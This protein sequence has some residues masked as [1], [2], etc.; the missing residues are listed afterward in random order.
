MTDTTRFTTVA[1]V[2]AAIATG[3]TDF[4]H[5]TFSCEF[6]G[7]PAVNFSG[8]N[9]SDALFEQPVSHSRFNGAN[10]SGTVFAQA[11]D[12]CDFQSTA[13]SDTRFRGTLDNSN[14]R[15][16]TLERV[17]IDGAFGHNDL[18]GA[19]LTDVTFSGGVDTNDFGGSKLYHVQFFGPVTGNNFAVTV[20][21]S[22]AF[23]N[24]VISN[25][26]FGPAFRA[27]N[28][29]TSNS[30]MADN[31]Y[32]LPNL[33]RDAAALTTITAPFSV[34]KDFVAGDLPTSGLLSAVSAL[35]QTPQGERYL[36]EHTV[37][38]D[39]ATQQFAVYFDGIH[40]PEGVV[41]HLS[42]DEAL[43]YNGAR[44]SIGA[45]VLEAAWAKLVTDPQY[46]GDLA[47][48]TPWLLEKA[49]LMI[50]PDKAAP[51]IDPFYALT[52]HHADAISMES[53]RDY[54]AQPGHENSV[55]TASR[56]VFLGQEGISL[57][58]SQVN[59]ASI[60]G[61]GEFPNFQAMN[62]ALN[63][64]GITATAPYQTSQPM[65]LTDAQAANVFDNGPINREVYAFD[66]DWIADKLA[67]SGMS[68][69]VDADGTQAA[70]DAT[71]M[72]SR[73]GVL[74]L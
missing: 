32:A 24:S 26:E 74:A 6:N 39:P 51:L 71:A 49:G 54:A 41:I 28:T 69:V 58:N 46:K 7:S 15:L 12:D 65:E 33:E 68:S 22:V 10:L 38:Y 21:D 56:G 42:Y 17:A 3:R 63:E 37:Q 45:T 18:G 23:S 40:P 36:N 64:E 35:Q 31:H 16:A 53:L 44:G 25:N 5:C 20:W 57:F 30:F 4:S 66:L 47:A 2:Q 73:T 55:Y 8:L 50:A 70:P 19:K 60:D 13:L 67:D 1:D 48:T 72:N 52:G 62:I 29:T 14:L 34:T 59:D 9:L 27:A 43:A 11:V 61:V